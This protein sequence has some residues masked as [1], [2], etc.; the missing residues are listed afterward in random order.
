M[1][2]HKKKVLINGALYQ[3]TNSFTIF[4]LLSYLGFNTNLI[5]IDYNGV[6]LPKE[7]WNRTGLN[8]NDRIEI[9]TL[10]GGG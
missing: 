3:C 4:S 5:V 9:L 1:Q 10:A 7:S 2:Q 8:T 6:I